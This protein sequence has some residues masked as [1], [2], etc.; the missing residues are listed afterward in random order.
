MNKINRR[1]HEIKK[2]PI[3]SSNTG[4]RNKNDPKDTARSWT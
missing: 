1:N 3:G 4:S 2:F